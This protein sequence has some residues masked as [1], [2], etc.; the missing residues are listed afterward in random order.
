M[1]VCLTN[2]M[3]TYVF[4]M[5]N[6]YDMLVVCIGSISQSPQVKLCTVV[7]AVLH[8]STI[9]RPNSLMQL[10]QG[11]RN[12]YGSPDGKFCATFKSGTEKRHIFRASFD[13]MMSVN[14]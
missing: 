9:Y 11:P 14:V 1:L 5:K 13:D 3:S 10:M 6:G 2:V 8:T 12:L 7:V 4:V